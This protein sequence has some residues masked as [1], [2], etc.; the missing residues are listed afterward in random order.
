MEVL[1]ILVLIIVVLFY[2]MVRSATNIMMIMK[3]GKD[4]SDGS[5]K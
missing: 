4:W 5:D 2:I 3:Y 1:F